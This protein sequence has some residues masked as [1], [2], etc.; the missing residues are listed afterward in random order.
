LPA[1]VPVDLYVHRGDTGGA[2]AGHFG[3]DPPDRH[4]QVL[5]V[6][7]VQPLQ[8][9]VAESRFE[10]AGWVDGQ[11]ADELAGNGVDDPDGQV[12]HQHE[13]LT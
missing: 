8:R 3:I 12:L 9:Q 5:E 7:R 6:R 11:F 2:L 10:S 4:E 1:D 13:D